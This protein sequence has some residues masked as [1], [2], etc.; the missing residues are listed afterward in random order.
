MTKEQQYFLHLVKSHLNNT[1][2]EA[3][4]D[5][6]YSELFKVSEIQD[7]TAIIAVELK[8]LTGENKLTKAQF[9]PFNQ[10]LGLTVQN[11][12]YK[13]EGIELLKKV[14]CKN[15]IRHL[16]LKGV[17]LRDLYPSPEL[18]TSGD[19]DVT[20]NK[21]DLEKAASLLIDN[22]FKLQQRSDIQYVLT[23]NNE[24]YQLKTYIDCLNEK[25]ESYFDNIFESN[26]STAKNEY[27]YT[28][29]PI[30]HLI[31]VASHMLKHFKSGGAGI[32]Q[33]CDIDILLRKSDIE[34]NEF[35]RLCCELGIEKSAKV[36]LSLCKRYFDTPIAFDYNIDDA[37][38]DTLENVLL[39]GGTF[40][41]G[42]GDIGTARL[43]NTI[44]ESGSSK[45]ASIKAVFGLFSIDKEALYHNYEFARKHNILLP[46]AYLKR[47]Y[48][49]VFK[50]GKGNI[51]HIKSMFSDREIASKMSEMIKELE[52]E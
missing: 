32:R 23:Y 34:L 8:K 18:R 41:Y 35:I 38:N 22:G 27:T 4:N 26:K 1:T 33:L 24:E 17:V 42:I 20:L 44:S 31:Y 45:S 6:D 30:N 46:A 40:G 39:N 7:M 50:R 28:L 3:P 15:E 9:S 36:L 51:K 25:H 43:M 13:I 2:P 11:Y 52:I 19:T 12:E 16:F 49:G 10:V 29:T 37:L 21:E 5:I 14:L 48:D 47:I